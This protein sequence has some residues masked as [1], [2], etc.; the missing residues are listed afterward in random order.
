MDSKMVDIDYRA[1]VSQ[2][3]LVYESPAEWSVEGTPI[4]NGRMGTMA[5]TTPSAVHFQINRCDVFASDRYHAGHQ[6]GDCDY[7]GACAQVTL[8]VG[9]DVFHTGNGFRQHLSVYD[10]EFTVAAA[11]IY[12]RGF[13]HSA[14]DV[15]VLQVDDQRPD[16]QPLRLTV[17]MWR[18]PQVETVLTL[19]PDKTLKT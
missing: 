5:W 17:S 8:D 18:P 10:A 13:V 3:D 14:D 16:P 12:V 15:M 6:Y 19:W 9:D 11:D 4:G 1:L 2:A 7:A